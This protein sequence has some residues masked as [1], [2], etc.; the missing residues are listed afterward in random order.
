MGGIS[1]M[2]MGK[3]QTHIKK[4]GHPPW[5]L[6]L[7]SLRLSYKS[8]TQADTCNSEIFGQRQNSDKPSDN[9]ALL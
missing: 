3:N 1:L 7:L 9:D 2:N 5:N 6:S 4:G 8:E